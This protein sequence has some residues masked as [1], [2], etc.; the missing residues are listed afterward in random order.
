MSERIEFPGRVA[1]LMATFN[2]EKHIHE[3][4]QSIEAQT[5]TDVDLIFR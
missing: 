4:L 2:G 5:W 1:V 3:Q